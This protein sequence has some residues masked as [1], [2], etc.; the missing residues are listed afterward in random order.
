MPSSLLYK[1]TLKT[2]PTTC[3]LVSKDALISMCRSVIMLFMASQT[4]HRSLRLLCNSL[5]KAQWAYS[6][7]HMK[8]T[9]NNKQILVFFILNPN[10]KWQI[11]YLFIVLFPKCILIHP[12]FNKFFLIKKW[13]FS[14]LFVVVFPKYILIRLGFNKI[15]FVGN[16]PCS[17]D[18][19]NKHWLW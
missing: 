7:L 1:V 19:V 11:S 6:T 8:Y 15:F 12:G 3:V 17:V 2:C 16:Y 10:K 4:L 14:Y 13:Q 9:K 5:F 18:I